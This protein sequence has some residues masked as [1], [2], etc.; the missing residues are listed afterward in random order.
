MKTMFFFFI[1]LDSLR[2]C[3][4][5]NL[6]IVYKNRARASAHTHSCT[7]LL[8][9][10]FF[11]QLNW[12]LSTPRCL[13][14]YNTYIKLTTT[15]TLPP[16]RCTRTLVIQFSETEVLLLRLNILSSADFFQLQV[17]ICTHSPTD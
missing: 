9:E 7:T 12:Y 5:K 3:S 14:L 6:E 1:N 15:N 16:T 4:G 2:M 13:L 11:Y 8:G 10:Y 17:V